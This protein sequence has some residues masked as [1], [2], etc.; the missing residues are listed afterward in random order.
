MKILVV[1]DDTFFLKLLERQLVRL[2]ASEVTLCDGAA[3]A[4]N[5]LNAV[6]GAID[7]IIVDLQMPNVDGVEFLRSLGERR[8]RG[9]IIIVSGES[10]RVLASAERLV[11]ASRLKV[12]GAVRKPVS[13]ERLSE[14]L[15][16]R[17]EFLNAKSAQVAKVYS[18]EELRESI[19]R[20]D[21][22]CYYQPQID[23]TTGELT[24]VES[25]VRW[26][27]PTDGI[28]YPDRFILLA[29]Q[30]GMISDLT[31]VVLRNSLIQLHKWLQE[32]L[33]IS[34]AVNVSMDNLAELGF[35]D[36]VSSAASEIGVSLERLVLE[37][38]ESRLNRNFRAS[39]DTLT[40]LK[41]RHVRLSIDDFG[42]GHSSLAQL[43][44]LPFDELKIDRGF[45]HAASHESAIR[46][47][48]DASQRLA[49]DLDLTVVAEGV[50]DSADF[51]FVRSWKCDAAQGYFMARPMSAANLKVWL[52]DWERRRSELFG[53]ST[54]PRV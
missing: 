36:F 3:A 20:G 35:P 40:R 34:V 28:V 27:H 51:D 14:C 16:H 26:M 45:V 22:V 29:E 19:S 50:E 49:H 15:A 12:Y 13:L 25:L 4:M 38:T 17:T 41:L 39:L 2:G 54:D 53:P 42:T 21:L 31:H 5:A 7:V 44:D 37:V 23:L 30:H 11:R 1:D 43:R 10:D 8:F 32:G 24:S 9:G 18:A 46:A 33:N 52:A 47:I 48:F 6:G